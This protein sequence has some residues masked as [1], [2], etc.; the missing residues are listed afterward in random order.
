MLIVAFDF[1]YEKSGFVQNI[2]YIF[3][4]ATEYECLL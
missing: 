3:C 2:L 4:F 1:W